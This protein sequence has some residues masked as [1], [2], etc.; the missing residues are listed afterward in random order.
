MDSDV[1]FPMHP[2]APR[3]TAALCAKYFTEFAGMQQSIKSFLVQ[4]G[5]SDSQTATA[6]SSGVE[7]AASRGRKRSVTSTQRSIASFFS[8]SSTKPPRQS[9]ATPANDIAPL[10]SD[11]PG[12]EYVEVMA[13]IG[14]K[15]KAEAQEWQQVLNGRP[16][17]TPPCHCGQP[18]VLRSVVK[19]GEN[20]GR[21]FFVCTKPAVRHST[22]RR[23]GCSMDSHRG[24]AHVRARRG[25]QTRGASFSSGQT[26]SRASSRRPASRACRVID[27][28]R[29]RRWKHIIIHTVG[30]ILSRPSSVSHQEPL[31]FSLH[32]PTSLVD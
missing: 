23:G 12:V 14:S 6:S 1:R 29:A 31:F 11:H 8:V 20:R 3:P 2:T 26:R 25:T 13:A 18:T 7:A 10:S 16:P 30:C 32:L 15:R 17:P 27:C 21:K 24:H 4:P 19:A 9:P 22:A 5:G 28:G